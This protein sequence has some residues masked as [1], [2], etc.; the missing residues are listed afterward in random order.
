VPSWALSGSLRNLARKTNNVNICLTIVDNIPTTEYTERMNIQDTLLKIGLSE[1]EIKVYLALLKRGR[2]TPS[3]L[4]KL[5][6]INR[7]TIYN[8]VKSLSS[9][10]IVAEDVGAKTLYATPLPPVALQ[11]VL[12]R[13][14]RELDEKKN[15][16][17]QAI[18][19]LSRITIGTQ[20]SVPKIQFVQEDGLLDFL[21]QNIG[22]WQQAALNADGVIW[23]FQDKSFATEFSAWIESGWKTKE[24]KSTKYQTRFLTNESDFEKKIAKKFSNRSVKFLKDTNFTSTLWVAGDYLVIVAANQHPHYLFEIHDATLAHNIQEVIRKLWESAL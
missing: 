13:S 6:K 20:Y 11:K 1:K 14:R 16:I 22:K 8:V 10:G 3:M 19:E 21:H 17:E 9:L 24:S 18:G 4:A 5:T 23:G 2:A 7:P 12:E 15:L